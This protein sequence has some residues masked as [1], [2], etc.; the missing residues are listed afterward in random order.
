MD[1]Y[2]THG[3]SSAHL[4]NIVFSINSLSKRAESIGYS[5]R[6]KKQCLIFPTLC[7][8]LSLRWTQEVQM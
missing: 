4:E 8:K 7:T 6:E 5:H 2:F 1:S 3:S